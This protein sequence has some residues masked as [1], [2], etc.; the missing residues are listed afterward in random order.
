MVIIT[1]IVIVVYCK[2]VFQ[3]RFLLQ[4]DVSTL[5]NEAK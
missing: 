4:F 1:V 2:I 5:K 3:L